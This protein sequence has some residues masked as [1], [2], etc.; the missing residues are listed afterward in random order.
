[1]WIPGLQRRAPVRL[2]PGRGQSGHSQGGAVTRWK[3]RGLIACE[4][5]VG[6][7]YLLVR[8]TANLAVVISSCTIIRISCPG[9]VTSATFDDGPLSTT[10]IP[11]VIARIGHWTLASNMFDL[12]AL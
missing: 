7:D 6:W 1:M 11:A 5:R 3:G 12:P 9:V 8:I 2:R 10:A 4:L